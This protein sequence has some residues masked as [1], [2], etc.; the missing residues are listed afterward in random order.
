MAILE[1][2]KAA[3]VIEIEIVEIIP[4]LGNDAFGLSSVKDNAFGMFDFDLC[5]IIDL[6]EE[7][8]K[9]T[10]ADSFLNGFCF[11]TGL[12]PIGCTQYGTAVK[13]LKALFGWCALQGLNLRPLPCEGSALPLS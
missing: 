5:S 1:I 12:D 9:G 2:D 11:H 8:F 4:A 6:Q 7:R 10:L 3:H 13:T